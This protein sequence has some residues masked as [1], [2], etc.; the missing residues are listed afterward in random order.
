VAAQV[1]LLPSLSSEPGPAGDKV[2]ICEH[3]R[4]RS[5]ISNNLHAF[6]CSLKPIRCHSVKTS[7]EQF[8]MEEEKSDTNA[9]CGLL[10]ES[11]E[12]GED[13]GFAVTTASVS[14]G[15]LCY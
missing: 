15:T 11:A 12:D 6:D 13:P 7:T 2:E 8:Y 5:R 10:L 3:F 14:N 1:L 4:N 9:E